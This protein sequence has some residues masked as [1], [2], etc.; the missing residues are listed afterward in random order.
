M[1]EDPSHTSLADLRESYH[2][3]FSSG[4]SFSKIKDE[5]LND[6]L[7]PKDPDS[8]PTDSAPGLSGRSI[9]WKLFL[10][11]H[12]PLQASTPPRVTSLLQDLRKSREH[13]AHLLVEK[14]RPPD[15]RLAS[16]LPSARSPDVA[17]NINFNNPLSQHNENPWNGWFEGLEVKKTISQDVERTFPDMPFF[18]GIAVQEQLTDILFV[19]ASTHP[20]IGYR[21][22]MHELL[23]PLF[24]AIHFDSVTEESPVE[25][26]LREIC[27]VKHVAGD[28]WALFDTVMDGVSTW[29]EWREPDPRSSV[30]QGKGDMPGHV[31]LVAPTG[32]NGLQ[33][34]VAPIV[35]ACNRI[36][37]DHLK[38]VDPALWNVLQKS[39]IEPQMY[40]IRWLRMLFTRE[41][42]MTEAMVLW[43][44]LFACDPSLDLA[45]WVCVA[46]LIRVRGRL[47]SGDYSSQ[48]T[49]L[50]R[51]PPPPKQQ[52]AEAPSHTS[53]LLQQ[54]LSLQMSPTISTAATITMENRSILGIP[55]EP[56][57]HISSSPPKRSALPR[58]RSNIAPTRPLSG[59][60]ESGHLRQASSPQLG[61]PEML[62]KG[63]LER[64]ESLGINKTVLSAVAELKRNIPDISS[65]IKSPVTEGFPLAEERPLPERPQWEP[66]SRFEDE[67]EM[68]ALRRRDKRLGDSLGW[69]VDTL[70]QD[71]EAAED[72]QRLRKQRGEA[73]ESLSYIRDVLMSDTLELEE[74]RLVS[75]EAAI[76]KRMK[77][78]SYEASSS[79]PS[80]P[81]PLPASVVHSENS[82][83]KVIRNPPT[84]F[85][86]NRSIVSSSSEGNDLHP[87][88]TAPW[89]QSRSSF[90]RPAGGIASTVLPRRPPPTSNSRLAENK[91]GI[92]HGDPLGVFTK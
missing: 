84:S 78:K 72:V 36:Q 64:G 12:E 34:W 30:R 50:L 9:A 77:R 80:I 54:A 92:V 65:F 28:A 20:H 57:D 79:R 56:A 49:T 32:P 44:A 18:R 39:G 27:S 10:A 37:N 86:P 31:H 25:P 61:I 14:T 38:N 91:G 53:M 41:F 40:G 4:L 82:S 88:Q 81:S 66:R 5:A 68:T 42:P 43:D 74:E 69:I 26:E 46:M 11:K 73:I 1:P 87:A 19:W 62:S 83:R 75:E 47:L 48:L 67:G 24:Y 85:T 60:R 35:K 63:L 13:W 15:E 76:A 45:Q 29:Y 8:H 23:A 71:E 89:N 59:L 6:R 21:Q 51:Y 3:I 33:P 7:F 16:D 22:G 58:H 55:I 90:S 52:L 2:H 70:L 17:K